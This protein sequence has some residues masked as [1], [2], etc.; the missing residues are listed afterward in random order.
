MAEEAKRTISKYMED[1]ETAAKMQ[2]VF[3]VASTDILWL[4]GNVKRWKNDSQKYR[5]VQDG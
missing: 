5:E 3:V 4:L 1:L 2:S